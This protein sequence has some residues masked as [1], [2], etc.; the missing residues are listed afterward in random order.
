MDENR[1][2]DNNTA[3]VTNMGALVKRDRNHPSVRRENKGERE[4]GGKKER[5][6]EERKG[7]KSVPSLHSGASKAYGVC[8]LVW[9][10]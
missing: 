7:K 5:K 6:K 9:W 8:G 2:F 3:Y 1:L 10:A 4:E